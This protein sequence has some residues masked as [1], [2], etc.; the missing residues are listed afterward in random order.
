M[1]RFHKCG[2]KCGLIGLL[3]L[4]SHG[5]A[6]ADTIVIHADDIARLTRFY[7]SDLGLPVL[8]ASAPGDSV[9]LDASGDRLALVP[10]GSH[11]MDKTPAQV[12]MTV[13]DLAPIRL[14]LRNLNLTFWEGID[15][16][17]GLE[18]IVAHDPEG[19]SLWYVLPSSRANL[20]GL[21]TSPANIASGESVGRLQL[22]LYG[23][24]CG[25]FLGASISAS[26]SGGTDAKTSLSGIAGTIL[27]VLSGSRYADQAKIDLGEFTALILAGNYG[28]W[29]GQGWSA[30]TNANPR[31]RALTGA[32]AGVSSIYLTAKVLEKI[33]VSSP[34]ALVLHSTTYWGAWYGFLGAS[35]SGL[36]FKND[37]A[38]TLS[39]ML[40]GSTG[41]LAVGALWAMNN[42]T[43]T[44]TIR[45]VNLGGLIGT[46]IGFGVSEAFGTKAKGPYFA[47][48]AAVGVL[49]MGV[50][51]LWPR[52]T[53]RAN[54]GELPDDSGQPL[55]AMGPGGAFR[56]SVLHA[57][58]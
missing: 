7:K 43:D 9:L 33:P 50:A 19:N 47:A 24:A 16:R 13:K 31:T 27:G 30:A 55:L 28:S 21:P 14:Q 4:F 57:S 5:R 3:V 49:G 54:L 26:V 25:A 53:G 23:G 58:F 12:R 32:L 11:V 51:T 46:A 39:T 48:P 1:S 52:L 8:P 56:I 6:I 42:H 2:F 17:G 18:G 44:K 36:D 35:M 40:W 15:V 20:L 22:M 34:Q 45:R 41:G 10:D 38:H 29:Q 37:R